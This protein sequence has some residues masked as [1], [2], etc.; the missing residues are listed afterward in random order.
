[1]ADRIESIATDVSNIEFGLGI[2][3]LDA[4]EKKI[5]DLVRDTYDLKLDMKRVLD[6]LK[7]VGSD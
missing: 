6:R 3:D 2:T 1:M 7:E 5:S 4:V